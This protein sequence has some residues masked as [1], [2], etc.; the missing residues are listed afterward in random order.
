[1]KLA[2]EIFFHELMYLFPFSSDKPILFLFLKKTLEMPTTV[3]KLSW[4]WQPEGKMVK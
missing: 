4:C 2:H 3:N 1:M